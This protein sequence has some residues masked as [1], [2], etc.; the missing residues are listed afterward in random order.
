MTLKVKRRIVPVRKK[1]LLTLKMPLSML[2]PVVKVSLSTLRNP[3]TR[4]ISYL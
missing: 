2:R 1:T 4:V 3:M